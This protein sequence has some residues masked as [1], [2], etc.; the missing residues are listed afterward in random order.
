MKQCLSAHDV[1]RL[2]RSTKRLVLDNGICCAPVQFVGLHHGRYCFE[3]KGSHEVYEIPRDMVE[4][5]VF[6]AFK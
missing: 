2:D 4:S 6:Q 3:A 1:N 5:S